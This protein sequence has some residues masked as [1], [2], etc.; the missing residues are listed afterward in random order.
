MI[1]L[2]AAPQVPV[3]L[4]DKGRELQVPGYW[5]ITLAIPFSQ[6]LGAANLGGQQGAGAG[7]G[8]PM[9]AVRDRTGRLV[10]GQT[11]GIFQDTV[12][13]GRAT[14]NWETELLRESQLVGTPFHTG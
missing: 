5:E 1:S 14:C 12:P 3:W 7:A 9:G 10:L 2:S 13:E 11:R 6:P 8:A 4:W